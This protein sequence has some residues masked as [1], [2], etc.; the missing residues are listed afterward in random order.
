MTAVA[1]ELLAR[2][3]V[4]RSNAALRLARAD[5]AA[6]LLERFGG[7]APSLHP[8]AIIGAVVSLAVIVNVPSEPSV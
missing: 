1:V 3:Q 4:E 8:H 5:R 7:Q 2:A 6:I